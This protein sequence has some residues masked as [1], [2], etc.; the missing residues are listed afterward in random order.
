MSEL[1]TR[2][3]KHIVEEGECWVWHGCV[4]SCGATPTMRY[5][6][7]TMAVRRAILL[8]R[9]VAMVHMQATYNCDNPK[10]V[11]PEHTVR[12]ERRTIQARIRRETTAGD[13]MLRKRAIA[14]GI[15]RTSKRIKLSME[16]AR[17]VRA[18]PGTNV[19][20]AKQF[21]IPVGEVG[22][23]MRERTWKEYASN[24]WSGLMR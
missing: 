22:A 18:A 10:C 11:N 3:R 24:P 7:K 8:D 4:Q 21:N 23:I 20:K 1:I 15:R 14:M 12:A 5:K 13:E 19:E 2:I 17:A 6:G 16:I 9:G